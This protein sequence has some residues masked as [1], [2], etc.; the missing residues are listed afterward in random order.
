MRRKDREIN[1]QE[2][3]AILEK[4]E[5]GIL[6][7]VSPDHEPY[8]VPLNYCLIN[9]HIYFHCAVEGKKIDHLRHN[10][11]V[12]FCVVGNT[13][14]MP[15]KFGTRYESCI[16]HGPASEAFGEE[17]QLALEGLIRKYTGEFFADGL[18][19]IE[20]SKNSTRIFKISIEIVSGKARK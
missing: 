4:G 19:Y 18:K 3:R 9:D 2:A 6:S 8:G 13:E 1:V 17:K 15:E 20:K 7:T 5:F 12:S 14:V 16:V 11:D 10:P